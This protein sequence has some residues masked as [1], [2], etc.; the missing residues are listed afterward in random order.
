MPEGAFFSGTSPLP[1]PTS[2][3]SILMEGRVGEWV[4]AAKFA[5]GEFSKQV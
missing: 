5:R 1:H 4:G 3:E 2:H